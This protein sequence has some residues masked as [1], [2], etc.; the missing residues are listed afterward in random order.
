MNSQATVI[1][2]EVV[3]ALQPRYTNLRKVGKGG[4]AFVLAAYDT[5]N[6]GEVA[7]KVLHGGLPEIASTRF[8]QEKAILVLLHHPNVIQ[9]IE[10]PKPIDGVEYYT[11]RFLPTSV[12]DE[13]E[14]LPQEKMNAT[15]ALDILRP[16][17]RAL[18]HIHKRGI[19]HRDIS[20]QNILTEDGEPWLCDFGIGARLDD[21]PL[22]GSLAFH[23]GNPQ[24]MAPEQPGPDMEV[25]WR[26]C[27]IYSLGA[28]AYR[29]LAGTCPDKSNPADLPDD[30]PRFLA[31]AVMKCLE[32]APKDRWQSADELVIALK[33]PER[34]TRPTGLPNESAMGKRPEE[35]IT[36]G[37]WE[38][39]Q[40]IVSEAARFGGQAVMKLFDP[41]L[42]RPSRSSGSDLDPDLDVRAQANLAAALEIVR[43]AGPPLVAL[44]DALDRRPLLVSGPEFRPRPGTTWGA[45]KEQLGPPLSK[46]IVP[47]DRFFREGGRAIGL[48]FLGL[49]GSNAFRRGLPL[50]CNA[51]TVFIDG[52]PYV[53]AI[54]DPLSQAVYSALLPHGATA[55][56]GA[57]LDVTD[58]EPIDLTT[59]PTGEDTRLRKVE[60]GVHLSR[61]H[62]DKLHEFFQANRR[63]GASEFEDLARRFG[64]IYAINSGVRAMAEVARG[65]LGGF[66]NK[67]TPLWAIAPGEVLLRACG[68]SVTD[69]K[70]IPIDYSLGE[71][72]S[73]VAT[74]RRDVHEALLQ[75]LG[76]PPTLET[77]PITPPG[78]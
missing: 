1:P 59:I 78:E 74:K 76:G 53:S 21:K 49:D 27:D 7:V 66:V 2:E 25:D 67:F 13:L 69:F 38:E 48:A 61:T 18:R 60:L 68:G 30:V 46:C 40:K 5:V 52:K 41:T 11:M 3:K 6:N 51:V 71:S 16:I 20:P 77:T 9:I 8:S 64:D 22:T 10:N 62:A 24:F 57:R 45:L 36:T 4:Y 31:H 26:L 28:T 44:A 32:S 72:T 50:F 29:M 58:G 39:I 56:P 35:T 47:Q 19:A 70:G 14:G 34:A 73:L 15:R 43:H 23:P 42:F 37:Q 33:A 65:A 12:L 17:S 54:C 63:S 55:P 75:T